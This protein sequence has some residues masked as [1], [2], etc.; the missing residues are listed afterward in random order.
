MPPDLKSETSRINGA[1]SHGPTTEAG[2]A[3]SSQNAIKHGMT[4]RNT[5]ILECENADD[6]KEFLAEHIA[7]H[8]PVTPPE[9]ELVEQ[10]AIARWRIRRFVN[11]E[12]VIID[13][14]IVRNRDKVEKEFATLGCGVHVAMAIRSLADESRCLSLMSRYEARHQ[15]THDKAYAALRELQK[16][17]LTATI[18]SPSVS[19][20]ASPAPEPPPEPPPAPAPT[21]DN[22][23]VSARASVENKIER[24]EPTD[25]PLSSPGIH[26]CTLV[27]QVD[28]L[29]SPPENG[30]S[31]NPNAAGPSDR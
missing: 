29:P 21:T 4:S 18:H 12:T 2:K 28:D 10:M 17:R 22:P 1:K 3:T 24:N 7:I 25:P 6:F 15:R 30:N 5:Y 8:Q 16:S 14:E 9:K 26:L 11:A 27:G 20:G 13:C 23:S 31:D 19:A